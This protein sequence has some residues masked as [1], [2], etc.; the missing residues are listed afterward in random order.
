M[1]N[2]SMVNYRKLYEQHFGPIPKDSHGRSLEIH[3]RDGDHNNNNLDNLQL[4]TIEEHYQIHFDQGDYGAC[5][6]MSHRMHLSPEQKS[7]LAKQC[8]DRIVKEGRHHW[9]GPDHNRD[10]VARGI[11][12]FLDR[13]AARDRNL[14]RISEGTHNLI[15]DTNPVHNLIANGQHHFQTNNPS[16]L[17]IQ[18]GTH[19][20][21]NSHPNKVQITCPHCGKT[22]GA[23]NMK[24][25]HFDN[26]KALKI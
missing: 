9:Q 22:G 6:I 26:C 2:N 5:L 3:H 23:V 18:D 21:L 7:L 10:L 25:Y 15:G 12:P 24:R 16:K 13:N 20:F 4:V 17:K 14:K 8:Q 19:H 11:H 1:V